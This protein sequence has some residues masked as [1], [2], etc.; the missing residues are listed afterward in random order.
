[1]MNGRVVT[2]RILKQEI[3]ADLMTDLDYI[4]TKEV[5]KEAT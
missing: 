5:V 2:W 3:V 1:M 4:T